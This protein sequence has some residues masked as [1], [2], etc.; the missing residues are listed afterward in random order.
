VVLC[1]WCEGRYLIFRYLPSHCYLL[2]LV[3]FDF[4]ALPTL[5]MHGQTKIKSSI[6]TLYTIVNGERYSVFRVDHC[7]HKSG[8]LC[9]S[10]SPESVTRMS[11][12]H[13]SKGQIMGV[14]EF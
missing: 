2:H 13:R 11:L 4:I 14:T 7:L 1:A 10:V 5:K 8:C 9:H 12:L 6:N 3:G